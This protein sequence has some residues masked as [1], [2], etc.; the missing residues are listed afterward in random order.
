MILV[1]RAV[2]VVVALAVLVAVAIGLY[3]LDQRVFGGTDGLATVTGTATTAHPTKKLLL[4]EGLAIRDIARKVPAVGLDATA[5]LDAV[6]RASPPSGFLTASEHP[7]TVEGFLFPATYDVEQPPAAGDFVQQQL[8][9][10]S[11][12][13]AQVDMKY[14]KGKNLSRYDVLKI[15]SMVER[16][17]V[18]PSDRA[19]IAA[20]IYNRLHAR[21]P[22]GIDSTIE[23][24][25]GAWREPTASELTIASPYNSRIHRGLPPTPISNPGLA[26]IKA[27]AHPAAVPY[28]YFYA[29]PGDKKGRMYFTTSYDDFLAYIKAHPA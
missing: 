13:F 29:I 18:A 17:A 16:E 1:R 19:K 5:Y 23:Y 3:R 2:G 28:L 12:A 14:A 25:I 4:I 27:A 24:A 22:L 10:F 21:V 6:R 11:V 9:A 26:S 15:A 7:A 20:V 8:D